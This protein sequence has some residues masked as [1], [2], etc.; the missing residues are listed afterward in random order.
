MF[1]KLKFYII[2]DRLN[3]L[4]QKTLKKGLLQNEKRNY[5]KTGRNAS[6]T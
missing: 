2:F 5:Y 1:C 3:K 6:A 4:K